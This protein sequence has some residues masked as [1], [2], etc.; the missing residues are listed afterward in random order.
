MSTTLLSKNGTWYEAELTDC[1]TH[2]VLRDS[3]D[4]EYRFFFDAEGLEYLRTFLGFTVAQIESV[5]EEL[6]PAA[7]RA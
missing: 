6:T 4:V 3:W 2:V 7:L 5:E 1:R